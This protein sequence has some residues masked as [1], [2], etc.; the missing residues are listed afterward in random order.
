M[1]HFGGSRLAGHDMRLAYRSSGGPDAGE[2]C[3][4]AEG[5]F[6]TRPGAVVG[7]EF[8]RLVGTT[9]SPCAAAASTSSVSRS[10]S[11]PRVVW[12]SAVRPQELMMLRFRS[13][14]VRASGTSGCAASCVW[15]RL[16]RQSHRYGS[17]LS[18]TDKLTFASGGFWPRPCENTLLDGL[19]ERST[20]QI[21]PG[22]IFSALL[23]VEGPRKLL[24]G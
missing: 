13:T 22:S 10:G 11:P 15:S 7:T 20:S 1:P 24:H 17:P 12:K 8:G 5:E 9:R 19:C 18:S 4:Q 21:D 6:R 16:L 2:R 23:M 3:R 14:S